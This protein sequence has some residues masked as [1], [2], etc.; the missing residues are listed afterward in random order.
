MIFFAAG[1][2]STLNPYSNGTL[3]ICSAST[4]LN[5]KAFL[6]ICK[7]CDYFEVT[8]SCNTIR[9][10]PQMIQYIFQFKI[11]YL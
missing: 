10:Y 5:K 4:E 11:F 7:C 9:V 6:L 8:K 1:D 3:N 2:A